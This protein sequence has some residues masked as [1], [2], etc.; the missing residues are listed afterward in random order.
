MVGVRGRRA[1]GVGGGVGL[2]SGNLYDLRGRL[3]DENP[4]YMRRFLRIINV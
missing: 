4:L 1:R 3:G 2:F